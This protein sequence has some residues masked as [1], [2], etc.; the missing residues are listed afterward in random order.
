VR[1]FGS[2]RGEGGDTLWFLAAGAAGAAPFRSDR[3][4]CLFVSTGVWFASTRSFWMILRLWF[5]L[6]AGAAGAVSVSCSPCLPSALHCLPLRCSVLCFCHRIWFGRLARSRRHD[7]GVGC[8]GWFATLLRCLP[9]VLRLSCVL[10]C[11]C[12]CVAFGA[13]GLCGAVR[14]ALRALRHVLMRSLG[15]VVV[16]VGLGGG[17]GVRFAAFVCAFLSRT[18]GE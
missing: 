16:G 12:S 10:V 8:G 3:V 15:G 11:R 13:C 7:A 4:C 17:G 18:R 1:I 14:R 9:S 5:L 2:P 6:A